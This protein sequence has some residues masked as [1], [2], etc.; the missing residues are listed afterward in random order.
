MDRASGVE[1]CPRIAARANYRLTF[2]GGCFLK[3]GKVSGCCHITAARAAVGLC[4]LTNDSVDSSEPNTPGKLHL[5]LLCF[6]LSCLRLFHTLTC[7]RHASVKD[8]LQA[9]ISAF[10]GRNQQ[11]ELQ[12]PV[13]RVLCKLPSAPLTCICGVAPRFK[14]LP[15]HTN[16]KRP[17]TFH[18]RLES[19][20]PPHPRKHLHLLSNYFSASSFP[21]SISLFF[22]PSWVGSY[23][24]A[25]LIF[26]AHCDEFPL[27][28]NQPIS[29][30]L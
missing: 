13:L 7:N 10:K 29:S 8:C 3:E 26:Q 20:S 4:Q 16:Q 1:L 25:H 2:G 9:T 15:H 6:I 27:A 14:L 17:V 11:S 18:P 21:S 19:Q 28:Y 5:R 24:S 22:E 23:C 12:S 30:K